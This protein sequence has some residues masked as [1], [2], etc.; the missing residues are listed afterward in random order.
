[1]A[2]GES[3]LSKQLTDQSVYTVYN[4]ADCSRGWP[5]VSLFHGYNTEV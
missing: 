1:M 4:L 2:F 3:L 5:E